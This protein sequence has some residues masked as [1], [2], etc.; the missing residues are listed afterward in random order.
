[1][2]EKAYKR[3][4]V[5]KIN[6]LLDDVSKV[7]THM[8]LQG[9]GPSSQDDVDVKYEA[10]YAESCSE[11]FVFL[12]YLLKQA[13]SDDDLYIVIVARPGPLQDIL[14]TYL[15][16]KQVSYTR[17]MT[18]GEDK[19]NIEWGNLHVT[20]LASGDEEAAEGT[21]PVDLVIAFDETFD[22]NE[23]SFTNRRNV[24]D[25]G[26]QRLPPIVRPV[27]YASLEHLD[28]CLPRTLN[29]IERLRKL[30]FPLLQTQKRVG[31]LDTD[32]PEISYCAGEVYNYISRSLV[33][34]RGDPWPLPPIRP[35]EGIS[36]MESDS[37]LSD[38][39]SDIS[40]DYKPSGPVRYWPNPV[41][42]KVQADV[43]RNGKRA[44]V[45]G[46]KLYSTAIVTDSDQD[47]EWSDSIETQ[48][49]KQRM[50]QHYN[51]G[52]IEVAVSCNS[53]F[54]SEA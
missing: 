30:V 24:S 51:A 53:A 47:L 44:F 41:P 3:E 37:S 49:K 17:P 32:E 14:E 11:K 13:I 28:L 15:K 45:S 22:E 52:H 46:S 16:A 7:T 54:S 50:A 42:P 31:S 20:L 36:F 33:V 23:F 34:D 27:V 2:E 21:D 48:A 38:A 18:N 26:K 40:D 10:E 4:T 6:T 25:T 35:I 19:S 39:K 29:P 43:E 5:E 1:M 8:D 12:G 9:S